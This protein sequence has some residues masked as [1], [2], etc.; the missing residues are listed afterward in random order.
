[1][2]TGWALILGESSPL[3]SSIKATGLG[4]SACREIAVSLGV[5]EPFTLLTCDESE[6]GFSIAWGPEGV[7]FVRLRGTRLLNYALRV[8]RNTKR[9]RV[10]IFQFLMKCM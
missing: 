9:I 8:F 3:S 1:M 5:G 4:M 2:Y 6:A 10:Q 7:T